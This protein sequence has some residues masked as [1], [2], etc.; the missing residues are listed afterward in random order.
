MDKDEDPTNTAIREM[1]EETGYVGTPIDVS[2]VIQ[3]LKFRFNCQY[4]IS[5][6]LGKATSSN[7]QLLC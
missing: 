6:I 7:E 5:A 2:I 4:P 3:V 1:K